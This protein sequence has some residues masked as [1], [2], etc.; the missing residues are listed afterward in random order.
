MQ[1][2]S[3]AYRILFKA[4]SQE[5]VFDWLLIRIFFLHHSNHDEDIGTL[6]FIFLL[7]NHLTLLVH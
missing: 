6:G 7:T 3:C 2:K 5:W 1:C 4:H